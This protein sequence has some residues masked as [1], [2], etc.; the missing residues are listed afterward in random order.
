MNSFF[1]FKLTFKFSCLYLCAYCVSGLTARL[2]T[3]L[4]LRNLGRK[5]Y[6]FKRVIIN[7][8][9]IRIN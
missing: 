2:N 8:Q 7:I 9:E 4:G 1:S 5:G 6:V 3:F